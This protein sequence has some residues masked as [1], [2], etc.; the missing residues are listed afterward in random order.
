[1]I[2]LSFFFCS[3]DSAVT[4]EWMTEA[5]PATTYPKT[6][7]WKRSNRSPNRAYASSETLWIAS[8][9]VMRSGMTTARAAAVSTTPV[10]P[11]RDILGRGNRSVKRTKGITMPAYEPKKITPEMP[12]SNE[13]GVYASQAMIV[14]EQRAMKEK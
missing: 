2:H 13:S 8:C 6:S 9:S 14:V 10:R 12:P 7:R 1:M 11:G 4:N 5:M 3:V